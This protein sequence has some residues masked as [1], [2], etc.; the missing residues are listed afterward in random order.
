MPVE[1]RAMFGQLPKFLDALKQEIVNEES[2]IWDANFKLPLGLLLQRKREKE[3]N[4]NAGSATSSM[5]G[6]SNKKYT[7]P[8]TKK[9]KR[10]T[11]G[12][13]ISDDVV[14]KAIKRIN[15]SN[16]TNKIDVSLNF[17]KNIAYVTNEMF[18]F[19]WFWP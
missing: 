1:K 19:S 8:L 14:L 18:V 2:P 5:P 16:Y 6:T 11:D 10:D 9:F 4:S 12:D 15:E 3:N 7:E 17:K 13:D